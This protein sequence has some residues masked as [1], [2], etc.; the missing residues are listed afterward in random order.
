MKC[1]RLALQNLN[2][3]SQ[4]TFGE[5]MSNKSSSGESFKELTPRPLGYDI[6]E[7]KFNSQ[8][9]ELKQFLKNES[10]LENT[11][12]GSKDDVIKLMDKYA[13]FGFDCGENSK[14]SKKNEV[15]NK[16]LS[17]VQ[18]K[19]IMAAYAKAGKNKGGD[20]RMVKKSGT[21]QADR[22]KLALLMKR[23][24]PLLEYVA[25]ESGIEIS[26]QEGQ[27][28]WGFEEEL[29]EAEIHDIS[30]ESNNE[31]KNVPTYRKQGSI[32]GHTGFNLLLRKINKV[33]QTK[34]IHVLPQMT[35]FEAHPTISHLNSHVDIPD[36]EVKG[37]QEFLQ[38]AKQVSEDRNELLF[39]A[40]INYEWSKNLLSEEPRT[41]E[42]HNFFTPV[43]VPK[44]LIPIHEYGL[45]KTIEAQEEMKQGLLKLDAE[46]FDILKIY[47]DGS[48]GTLANDNFTYWQGD[49]E[50]L[51]TILSRLQHPKNFKTNLLKYL[52]I[53][54]VPVSSEER[55]IMMVRDNSQYRY[56]IIKRGIVIGVAGVCVMLSVIGVST[57]L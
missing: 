33:H 53:G 5:V 42:N 51:Y 49:I 26:K 55:E 41:I 28:S 17:L 27:E 20:V 46:K 54:W 50:N 11:Q 31:K 7:S 12:F 8:V 35:A 10:Q 48:S 22:V 40:K 16:Q 38:N 23:N 39:K 47:A 52:K 37:L 9:G 56:N 13:T 30:E 43:C 6:L 18:R 24:W 32:D 21:A 29:K 34:A 36:S 19:M 15:I 1:T 45:Q 25:K 4:K 3:M 44:T 14:E 2:S 57:G